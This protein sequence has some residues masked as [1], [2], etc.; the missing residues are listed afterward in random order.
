MT[1]LEERFFNAVISFCNKVSDRLADKIDWEQRR[2]EIA[3]ERYC[4]A[5]PHSAKDAVA[6]ADLLIEELKK[7]N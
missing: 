7:N 5:N 2:Y 1:V 4:S 3:K 6:C